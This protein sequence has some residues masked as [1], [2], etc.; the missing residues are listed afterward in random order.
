M[1]INECPQDVK[2]TLDEYRTAVLEALNQRSPKIVESNKELLEA[3]EGDV[4]MHFQE[5]ST[6]EFVAMC[7]NSPCY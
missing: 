6:P 5:N 7:W 2:A 1:E 4:Q 3:N